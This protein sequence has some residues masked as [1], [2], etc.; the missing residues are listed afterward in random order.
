MTPDLTDDGFLDGRLR[1][2]QPRT[3]Y[4]AATDPVLLAASVPAGVGDRALE[5][6]CGVGVAGLCLAL[7]TGAQVTGVEVQARYADLA[8]RNAARNALP[9]TV[10]EGDLTRLTLTDAFDHVLANPPYYTAGSPSA[11]A[12]RDLALRGDLPLIRWME[13]MARRARHGGTVT[14]IVG[15]DRLAEVLRD[16]PATLG[17]VTV[18]PLAARVGRAAK[19]VIVQARK[20]GR[21]AF[22]LAAPVIL[23]AGA[24]HGGDGDD[25]TPLARLILRQGG[26]FPQ[27]L[28]AGFGECDG[29]MKNGA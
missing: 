27:P 19:R 26:G 11:D 12:G 29:F 5:L 2:W 6:G 9:L 15:A 20:G 13:V 1:V 16:M 3:G 22:V 21:G 18:L 4:R 10:V 17:S 28:S 8:R 7:R 14:L 25:A 24:D 23:H